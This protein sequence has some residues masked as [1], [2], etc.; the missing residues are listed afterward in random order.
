MFATLSPIVPELPEVETVKRGLQ[1]T[2]EGRRFTYVEIRRAD[3]RIPFPDDFE[4]RLSGRRVARLWRRAKCIMA[5]LDGGETLVI[6]LGMSGRITVA[7]KGGGY[8][9]DFGRGKHDHVVFDTDAPARIVFTDP[10]RFGLMTLVE[11]ASLES[12]SLF[13]GLGVE[14]LSKQLDANHLKQMLRGKKTPIKSAL[15]DQRVIAGLGNIYVCEALWRS[16]ISPRRQAA[17]VKAAQVEVLV[18]TIKKVLQ[19]ALSAGGSSLRDHRQTN[20]ALGHFQKQFAVYDREGEPCTKRGCH[21]T[22]KRIVQ[23]GRSSFY[24]PACQV[25]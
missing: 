6:H 8:L 12:H 10:R 11:T 25:H 21:S 23:A 5:D 2:V 22:I 9:D 16:G 7:A 15:L 4:N 14:P 13:K 19:E 1:P 20:G 17:K 3:L 18:P 24:C